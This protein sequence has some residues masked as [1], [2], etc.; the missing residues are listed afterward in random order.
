MLNL[1]THPRLRQPIVR[2]NSVVRVDVINRRL[3][4]C[5]DRSIAARC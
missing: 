4:V 5:V 1:P 3:I 2:H